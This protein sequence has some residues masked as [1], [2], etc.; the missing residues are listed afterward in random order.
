MLCWKEIADAL[1]TI[2]SKNMFS[3]FMWIDIMFL[4]IKSWHSAFWKNI[5]ILYSYRPYTYVQILL[6]Y[7][8]SVNHQL[9][10][11]AHQI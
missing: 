11:F 8:L 4:L 5:Q 6:F 3:V 1:A 9:L 2:L 7:I 10:D